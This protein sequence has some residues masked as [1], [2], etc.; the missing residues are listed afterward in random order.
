MISLPSFPLPYS[1]LCSCYYGLIGKNCR[2]LS[3][4]K[5]VFKNEKT[6]HMGQ[7]VWEINQLGLIMPYHSEYSDRNTYRLYVNTDVYLK[8]RQKPFSIPS[9]RY[10]EKLEVEEILINH[11]H[12]YHLFIQSDKITD[13][14]HH[15]LL[16]KNYKWKTKDEIHQIIL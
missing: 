13:K 11:K 10:V 2:T 15:L 6:F 9:V 1:S 8:N 4:S 16:K 14:T 7:W 12:I 3:S 5:W